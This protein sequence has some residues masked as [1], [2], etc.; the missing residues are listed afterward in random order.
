MMDNLRAVAKRVVFKVILA[1]IAVSFVLTEAGSY[2]LGSNGDYVA[3]VNGYQINRA[4]L[5]QAVQNER[6]RQQKYMGEQFSQLV[7]DGSYMRQMRQKVL[8]QLIDEILLEQYAHKLE[9]TISDDHIRQTIYAIPAFSTANKFDN[10]KFLSLI[11]NIGVSPDQY[12][13]LMRRQLL[14]QQLIQGIGETGF[15]LP[16]EIDRIS[17][18]ALQRR[19]ARLATFDIAALSSKQNASDDEIQASYNAHKIRYMSPEIFKVSYIPIDIKTM[20]ENISVDEHE[21]QSWYDKHRD[22]LIVPTCKRYSI[23]QSKNENDAND[24]LKKLQHGADFPELAKAYSTD[25]VSAKNGG[26]I[27]WI[28]EVDT[29]DEL[30]LANLHKKGELSDVI[31]SSVGFLIIRLDDIKNAQ[32][33]PLSEIHD[34]VAVRVKRKKTID[35]YYRLQQ[36]VSDAANNNNE[37]LASVENIAGI[38][39]HETDWFSRDNVPAVLNYDAVKQVLFE[40]TLLGNKGAPGSN[41]DVIAVDGN[42]SFVI[43][44]TDYRPE[45]V[46]LL[47]DVRA[48]VEQEVKRQKALEQAIVDAEKILVALRQNSNKDTETLKAAG[49]KFSSVQH[50]D[51]T[52]QSDTL[53]QTVFMQPPPSLHSK[54]SYGLAT[55]SQ[56]DIV[57][58][59]LDKVTPQMLDEKQHKIFV[60]Q[61]NQGI[62]N[63]V[64]NALLANLRSAAKIKIGAAAQIQ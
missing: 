13:A 60:D 51:S 25:I 36:K 8:S 50:F 35:A 42:C 6:N 27:G 37:T 47:D 3:K 18:V 41:S 48:Q 21:I 14:A 62:T 56:G 16:S 9:L 40:G 7:T 4:Q 31:K 46:Q 54:S 2:L 15:L 1:F 30:K 49:L 45:R 55:N 64:F 22:Q 52:N 32:I 39:A 12:A 20:Q 53:A 23:I 24:W 59:A 63:M 43:R 58:I 61:L 29:L 57:L 10:V 38:K 5:E 26:D 17:A 33:S 44:I 19:E 11:G 28:S 34:E